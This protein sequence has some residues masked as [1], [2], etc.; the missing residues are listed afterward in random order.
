VGIVRLARHA[1]DRQDPYAIGPRQEL[2]PRGR[3]DANDV[4]GV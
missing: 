3:P 1:A 4:I 2:A